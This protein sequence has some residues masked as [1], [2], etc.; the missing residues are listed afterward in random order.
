MR[1]RVALVVVCVVCMMVNVISPLFAGYNVAPVEFL[2][3]Y[4]GLQTGKVTLHVLDLVSGQENLISVEV[5]RDGSEVLLKWKGNIPKGFLCFDCNTGTTKLTN[6]YAGEQTSIDLPGIPRKSKDQKEVK[7]TVLMLLNIVDGKRPRPRIKVLFPEGAK[8]PADFKND[9]SGWNFSREYLEKNAGKL[10]TLDLDFG[11]ACSLNCPHCFRRNGAVNKSGSPVLSYAET[12]DVIHQA[13][14]LGLEAIKILGAGEP[15]ENPDFLPFLHEMKELGVQ[16]NIFT[17]GHVFG[18]SRLSYRYHKMTSIRL[19]E[20]IAELG[21]SLNVGFNSFDSAVQDQMVGRQGYT[22]ERNRGL[23]LLAD[24]GLNLGQPT[25]LCLAMVPITKQNIHEICDIYVWAR[26]RN[27][28]PLT[29]VS[30]CAG[31]ARKAWKNI[32]PSAAEL[33]DLYTRINIYNIEKGISTIDGLKR[34][35]ISSYAG[36]CPCHQVACGMYV[37]SRGIVLR[38]PGDDVTVFGNVREESL[39]DIWYKSENYLLHRGIFNCHC[40]PKDGKSIPLALYDQVLINVQR[41]FGA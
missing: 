34:D 25:R 38:C 4:C 15:F 30:M 11:E 12:M 23:E 29:T 22:A 8:V 16:V 20:A 40:P 33:V 14:E 37:T 10:L 24:V 36:G 21:V 17:K 19:A 32:T 1:I 7:I 3:N 5:I 9:V 41:H 13:K 27:I 39:A 28:Y 35:G 2:I 31:R 26:E 18:D 6:R